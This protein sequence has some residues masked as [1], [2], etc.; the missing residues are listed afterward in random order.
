MVESVMVS[1]PS[2]RVDTPPPKKDALWVM[3][4]LVRV[5]LAAW[6][7]MPPPLAKIPGLEP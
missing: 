4:V 2:P 5:R 3:V 7:L 6:E 1:V